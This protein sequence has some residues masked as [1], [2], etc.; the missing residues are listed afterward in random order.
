MMTET[1]VELLK[2]LRINYMEQ[3]KEASP[4]E[5]MHI[6]EQGRQLAAN[7]ID[8]Q[9][10]SLAARDAEIAWLRKALNDIQMHAVDVGPNV[11]IPAKQA[12][13]RATLEADRD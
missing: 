4:F 6:Y 2:D 13:A 10:A 1:D 11:I 8:R 7:L 3:Y 9:T 12:I 5:C